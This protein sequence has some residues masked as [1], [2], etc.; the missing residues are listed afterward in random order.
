[1]RRVNHLRVASSRVICEA[2]AIAAGCFVAAAPAIVLVECIIGAHANT[3]RT[4]AILVI[5]R[6][7]STFLPRKTFVVICDAFVLDICS[8]SSSND[9][10]YQEALA[11]VVTIDHAAAPQLYPLPGV[12]DPGEVDVQGSL[13]NAKDDADGIEEVFRADQPPEPIYN[14]EGAVAAERNQIVAVQNRR[15]RGLSKEQ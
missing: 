15:D 11:Q 4:P 2:A 1:M 14:V 12:V 6:D 3:S 13:N 10:S 8:T 5:S 9:S 7:C